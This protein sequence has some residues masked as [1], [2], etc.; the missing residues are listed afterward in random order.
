MRKVRLS[1]IQPG[2][3][4]TPEQLNCLSE[5]FQPDVQAIMA[6][7]ALPHLELTL[8]L[9]EEAAGEGCD[10]CLTSEDAC[11]ISAYLISEPE[12]F[13]ALTE[14]SAQI[15]EARFSALAKKYDTHVAACYFKRINGKNYNVLSI[16]DRQG[17][18]SGM[19]RKTH[20]PPN[21]MWQVAAGEEINVIPL[22]FGTV[23][24]A[25]CYDMMFPEML[26]VLKMQGAELVL[27]P[28]A[29][30]GWYDSIGEA[31]LRTRANDNALHILTAK[32]YHFLG[33]GRSGF[34]DHWGQCLA[35]A[36]FYENA[37]V[38]HTVDLDIPKTQP[39][40]FYPTQMSGMADVYA[41]ARL[42]RRPDLYGPLCEP[43]PHMQPP[44]AEARAQLIA[45]IKSGECRW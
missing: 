7:H 15:A 42:E 20:L 4:Q 16:F 43:G 34:V 10:L 32:N 19:Y 26:S 33:A 2:G 44:D 25:I 29:G 37:V 11:Q 1:A 38:R 14:Q 28:T 23:G 12:L 45:R 41:R 18:L 31:A 3:L 21:E 36:G 9:L 39:D 40:W 22:D 5:A 35:D 30:Y 8:S 6:G 27:H 24:G 13:N 17:A